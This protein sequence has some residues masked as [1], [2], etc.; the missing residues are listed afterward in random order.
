MENTIKG[1]VRLKREVAG[2]LQNVVFA[3]A[4]YKTPPLILL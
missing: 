2:G 3:M 1:G 4:H